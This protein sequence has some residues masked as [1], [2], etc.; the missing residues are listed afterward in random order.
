ME[1]IFGAIPY[2]LLLLLA[3]INLKTNTRLSNNLI[4]FYLFLL[5]AFR[6]EVGF[7]YMSYA[8]IISNGT[9]FSVN[10]LEPAQKYLVLISRHFFPQLFFIVNSFI[11]VYF[12]KWALQRLSND[13]ALSSITF[14]TFPL[15]FLNSLNIIRFWSALAIVF[16]A[17]TFLYEKKYIISLIL[18]LISLTFHNGAI[19]GLL[20]FPLYALN[21]PLWLNLSILIFGFVG[22][23]FMLSHVLERIVPSNVYSYK[24]LEYI[25]REGPEGMN[26]IPYICLLFD[27][28]TFIKAKQW[29]KN[30]F[31]YKC[32]TIYNLGISLMFLFS[33]QTTLS[34]RISLPFI[35]YLMILIPHLLEYKANGAKMKKNNLSI[36]IYYSFC[37]AL[38]IY[39]ITI[40]NVSLGRSQ[41]L[42]YKLFFLQ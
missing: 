36:L 3:G 22:G 23:E 20:F 14:I 32:F 15:L 29:N 10:R 13:V 35:C 19:I 39:N 1:I 18:F 6:F 16:Y 38:L 11:S 7:D 12:T 42:P 8:D 31:P 24:L 21:I 28:L 41:Y 30:Q 27:V 40:Y 33:F 4:Y 2:I 5:G 9:E 26:K 17:S 37:C 25:G 34:I